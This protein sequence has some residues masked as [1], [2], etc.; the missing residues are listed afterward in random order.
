MQLP[1]FLQDDSTRSILTWFGT[2]VAT[3]VGAAWAVYKF[4]KSKAKPES[5]PSVS[6]SNGSIAAGRDIR[7]KLRSDRQR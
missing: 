1:G 6:A 7:I 4:Q 2:G 3:I 5:K